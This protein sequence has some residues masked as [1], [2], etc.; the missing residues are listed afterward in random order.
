MPE[1]LADGVFLATGTAAR[2]PT[3]DEFVAAHPDLKRVGGGYAGPCPVCAGDNRFHVKEGR[4]GAALWGC[5][6][7]IDNSSGT[8]KQA[9]T[10]K[11]MKE[12]FADRPMPAGA[13]KG[14]G[15]ATVA[16]EQPKTREGL[17]NVLGAMGYQW[18]Y[19]Q[20]GLCAELRQGVR[21]WEMTTDRCLADIRSRIPERFTQSGTDKRLMFG[22][23]A[24]EDCFLALLN[25]AESD[26]FKDWLEALPKWHGEHRLD[27]WLSHVFAIDT[28]HQKL[29]A[30]GSRSL[31]LGAVWRTYEPGTKIDEML[32]LIG[33]Q[34]I[35][36]STAPRLLLPPEH[37]EWFTDGLRLSA[38]DKHRAET[39]QRRVI[40][41]AAEMAGSTRAD[42]ESLK[43][44]LSRTDD[45]AVRLVWRRNPEVMLR[46]CM[47]VGTSNDPHCLPADP[48]GNR[49]F[50]AVT[51]RAGEDGATGVR[52]Y[53][54][55]FREQLWAEAL[56]RYREGETAH[57]PSDLAAVQTRVNASAV[58]V[59]ETLEDALLAFVG[60]WADPDEWFRIADARPTV[61]A[62]LSGEMPSDKRLSVELQRLGCE[63]MGQS[64]YRGRKGRWW[65]VPSEA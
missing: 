17:G 33:R 44:F 23:E 26:P 20:R 21:P 40:V 27:S 1:T 12:L 63:F 35:G 62:K 15:R 5:R 56:H 57:L 19:N 16:D 4:D 13:R 31:L 2:M 50:V 45:G 38:E 42:R 3:V 25:R 46:R 22:R 29:A 52:L 47:L 61:Q 28:E 59:D 53:L 10:A 55:N 51:V 49:R 54:K 58:Q 36:K 7:C 37:P 39:L 43:A 9:A 30:W 11:V 14:N 32:V 64:R 8:E 48:A 18:R 6:G 60:G 24:F 34:G 65:K 41:E